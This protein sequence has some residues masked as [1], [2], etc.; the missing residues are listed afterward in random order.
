MTYKED[1]IILCTIKN[2]E[3][4]TVFVELDDK[5]KGS[6]ALS[7]VSAGRIRNIREFVSA[8]KKVVCKVLRVR[9]DH[10][11]LSLR[12]VTAKER[13]AVLD[14]HKKERTFRAILIPIF[15][16][17]TDQTLEKIAKDHD[18]AELLDKARENPEVLEK[19]VSKT[20]MES[21]KKV[22]A[23]KRE[24]ERETKKIIT[25]KTPSD[26]GLYDIQKILETD[27]AEVHYLGSSRFSVTV[28]DKE[29]KAANAKILLV[30]EEFKE[31]AK[32]KGALFEI[33]E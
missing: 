26:A 19:Y 22:L 24:K 4:T 16:E 20:Q 15:A 27:R 10:L 30:L 18:L 7:E 8:G 3:S 13:E 33:K 14:K 32:K 29:F 11:E 28:K 12:R 9:P 25:I 17:K 6:I 5:T 21:L 23:E 1:D 31:R 2:I